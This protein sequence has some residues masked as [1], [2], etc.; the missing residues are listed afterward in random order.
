MEVK[1]TFIF[2]FAV[3]EKT[4][5]P[6]PMRMEHL[7]TLA[8]SVHNRHPGDWVNH[9]PWC[10]AAVL[11][12]GSVWL[13]TRGDPWSLVARQT[14]IYSSV[15]GIISSII[16]S[17]WLKQFVYMAGRKPKPLPDEGQGYFRVV[18]IIIALTLGVRWW[19]GITAFVLRRITPVGKCIIIVCTDMHSPLHICLIWSREVKQTV[20]ISGKVQKFVHP[21]F[22]N[23][24]ILCSCSH[25]QIFIFVRLPEILKDAILWFVYYEIV[26]YGLFSCTFL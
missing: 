25:Q 16:L 15:W 22:F 9:P 10:G 2:T 19:E 14:T 7:Q 8:R 12:R 20:H 6:I 23:N 24:F 17:A 4:H 5:C 18:A 3:I 26:F 13:P 11:V 1:L 21:I